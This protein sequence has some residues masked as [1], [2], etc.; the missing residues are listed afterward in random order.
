MLRGA[1]HDDPA[2]LD[3]PE[4]R[5]YQ[6]RHPGAL[7]EQRRGATRLLDEG[8]HVARAFPDARP[9]DRFLVATPSMRRGAPLIARYTADPEEWLGL[10]WHDGQTGDPVRITC[11]SVLDPDHDGSIKHRQAERVVAV[12]TVRGFLHRYALHAEPFTGDGSGARCTPRT[13]GLVSPEVVEIVGRRSTGRELGRITER[14][15]GLLPEDAVRVTYRDDPGLLAAALEEL[16]RLEADLRRLGFTPRTIRAARAGR[17][18]RRGTAE[19]VLAAARATS[20]DAVAVTCAKPDCDARVSS[21][22]RWCPTHAQASSFAKA[23]WRATGTG[24]TR[25]ST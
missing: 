25:P 3:R 2:W 19:R 20:A 4:V 1:H 7:H 22:Q 13:R 12:R 6:A 8:I 10:E 15:A 5:V 23:R 21:R 18:L 9:Y 17:T 24:S 11:H 16:P 14:Q